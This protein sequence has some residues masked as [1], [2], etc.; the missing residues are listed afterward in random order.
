MTLCALSFDDL[1]GYSARLASE[2]RTW[3][4]ENPAALDLPCDIMQSGSVRLLVQHIFAVELRYA[5]RLAGLP[6]SNYE[7]LP[8][9]SF[10][11]M[12]AIHE[13]A[14]GLY[15][16]QLAVADEAWLE[17]IV[18]MQTRS[19]GLMRASRRSYVAHALLHGSRHWAQIATVVRQAG[20]SSIGWQDYLAFK[21]GVAEE[22]R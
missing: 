17:E 9:A 12:F 21:A 19:G 13:E 20:F 3:F 10:E 1:L 8:R 22:K 11:A 18:E 15:R 14:A 4:A 16:S 5:Q 2:W 7:D 6:A